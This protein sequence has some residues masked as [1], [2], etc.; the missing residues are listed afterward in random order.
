M[1]TN[2][3][4]HLPIWEVAANHIVSTMGDITI[5]YALTKPEIFTLAAEDFQALHQAWV[6]AIKILPPNTVLHMQDRFT[7][8][9]YQ[10][11]FD[12][13]NASFLSQASERF[14]HDAPYLDHHCLLYLSFRPPGHKPANSAA[15]ALLK[16]SLV[17]E[18]T[19]SPQAIQEFT[20][21]CSQFARILT[22]SRLIECRRLLT[23]ELASQ[24]DRA[25]IIEQYCQLL[26][27]GKAP[28]LH[29]INFDKGI[30]IGDD[31]CLLY[32]LADATH[33]P[34]QCNSYIDYTPYSTDR[35]PFPIGFTTSLGLLLRCNHI[36]NQYIFIGDPQATMKQLEQKRRR[37]QS[38]AQ[39][40]RENALAR[41]AVNEFLN[42]AI[43]GQ[44][45]LVKAHFNVFA[46]TE[47]LAKLQD[48][49]NRVASAVAQ[50]GATPHLET[51]G[52]PQIWCAGIPGNAADFPMNETFDS[53]AEQAACFLTS[54]TNYRSLPGPFGIRLGDRLSGHPLA[55]DMSAGDNRNKFALGGSGSGKSFFINHLMRIYFERLSHILIVDIGNS[56]KGLCEFV[57]GIYF[58]YTEQT[59]ICFNPFWLPEGEVLDTEKRE[60]IKTLLLALWKKD[61]E[62]FLRS[63]YVALSNALQLYY[64]ELDQDK[65]I[66]PCFNTF[67]EFLQNGFVRVLANDRVKE[68]D[69][70]I[71]NFLYVLRP[72]YKKGEYDYL[73]NATTHLDLLHQRMIVFE[74]DNIKDHPI[75][76]VVV[77]I[78]IMET[79]ISKMR[80]L[81]GIHKV[82][83]IEEAWKALARQGMG[84]YIQYLFKTV[85]KFYGEAIVVTQEVEDI[86]SSPIVKQAIINNSGC[87]ILLDQ[88]KFQNKFDEIQNLLGLTEKDK[89]LVLSVNKDNDP[90]RKYKE[91]FIKPGAANSKVYRTE[92][93]LEEYLTYTTEEPEKI[94]VQEYSRK[95]G[96]LRKGITA[97]AAE[98]RQGSAKFGAI[99]A[100]LLL[101]LLL[102]MGKARA[103]IPIV[104]IIQTAI[105]KV[106]VAA[107]LAV[108]RLQTQTIFLQEAQK[109]L[110]NAMQNTQLGEIKDWVQQQKD[111]YA[112]YYQELWQVK[113]ALVFYEKVKDML[114]KQEQLV[115]NYKKAY[116]SFRQDPHFSAAEYQ[117]IYTVCNGI[118]AQSIANIQQLSLVINTLTTQMEDG[119]RL[120]I[121]DAAAVRIDQNYSDLQQFTQENILLSLQ[122]SKDQ[123]DLAFIKTL[124]GI[125]IP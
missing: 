100:L 67:Y 124:Y 110:E 89:A 106:I 72:F 96:S 70:D 81:P 22:D 121:I 27:P 59:P 11:N 49:K 104:E 91:V 73:L 102:P 64:Q 45:L 28:E 122:R 53:F 10:G 113:N 30:R 75:L 123:Q 40:S 54:E 48:L 86:I 108:Q 42:E 84:E 79:F 117:H 35:T 44:R 107:D 97:L 17:P 32:T 119:D 37:L 66:F 88:S 85:R 34:A 19:L 90:T 120:H 78:I 105:K 55:V 82:I 1:R 47:D 99:G 21:Q 116:A 41:D 4:T 23:E 63:E 46:W 14:H 87:K 68:K 33:L 20:G 109:T 8:S 25:G 76:F 65:D 98:L 101:S 111:L 29:D 92:V 43:A 118:L 103:Q 31:H 39:H 61:D 36:Y 15:S 93:S 77:T 62:A 60:S 112:Q 125:P 50:L 18:D 24:P 115:A 7:Q 9:R 71:D 16:K 13:P 38:L 58:T 26:P 74:L 12:N 94:K 57:E 52:A 2:L 5:V 3:S 6:R 51:V 95:Y 69:F 114:A 80:R 83:L 56:Y